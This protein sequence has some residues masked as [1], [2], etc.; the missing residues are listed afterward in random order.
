MPRMTQILDVLFANDGRPKFPISWSAA[1]IQSLR[2]MA[3]KEGVLRSPLD[4]QLASAILLCVDGQFD[5]AE[6]QV[7]RLMRDNTDLIKRH[8]ETF[9]SFLFAL[10]V[11]QQFGLVAAMLQDR[12][13]F[14][15]EFSID[16]EED[17]PGTGR[18]RWEISPSGVHRFVFD[19]KSYRYDKTRDDIL[20]FY[21]EFPLYA[22]FSHS[23]HREHGAIVINQMDIGYTP[24]LSWCDNRPDYFLVPDCIFVPTRGYEYART[25]LTKN[26]IPWE[27]R[28]DLVFWRG[29]TTGIPKVRGDWR[30]LERIEL[31]Q[32]ARRHEHL[33]ILDV[34]LS[35][36]L[37]MPDPATVEEVKNSGLLR[38]FVPW[39]EWGQF[40]YHIDID[41]NSSPW[42][43]LFQRLLTGS[44]VLKVESSRALNQ[45]FYDELKPWVNYI[46]I[47]ADM[48]DLIEKIQWLRTNPGFAKAVGEAGRQLAL[49]MT[50]EREIGR[51]IH[52]VARCFRY[53][54]GETDGCGPFGRD[55]S[56]R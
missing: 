36:V 4:D 17:G 32:I 40:R 12:F 11:L 8:S 33:G 50:Y 46:P 56:G 23:H 45:W 49:T 14:K 54:R 18:V 27:D 31:C 48:S 47:A 42:S 29:G 6:N 16:M 43:N 28:K 39:E 3:N 20:G 53:F 2:D 7:I 21:W 10:Y 25:I 5:A 15:G 19:A 13:G 44:P 37:Q 51:S 26:L 9:I 24:G 35:S 52:T 1:R 55:L 30:S 38:G 22:S 34:G 41:G